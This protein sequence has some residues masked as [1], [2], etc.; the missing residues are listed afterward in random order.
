MESATIKIG[1]RGTL[2][3]PAPIRQSYGLE[4]GDLISIEVQ[5]EGLLLRPLVTIPI[6]KYSEED[7][8]RF[9]LANTV[10]ADD[11]AWA[12]AEV[13]RMGLDPE[14]FTDGPVSISP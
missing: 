11:Y 5:R 14:A 3:I 8:A 4:E 12:V 6:E 7:K 9:L 2:V 10:T 1:K 13:R